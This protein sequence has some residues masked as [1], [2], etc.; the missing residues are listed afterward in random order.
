MR[1]G[2]AESV[3]RVAAY[4][5]TALVEAALPSNNQR[6]QP[7]VEVSSLGCHIT[8]I[9]HSS[10][11]SCSQSKDM[12]A[13]DTEFAYCE[14]ARGKGPESQASVLCLFDASPSA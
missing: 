14:R 11:A 2:S 1:S 13:K 7:S 10:A 12:N 8:G 9:V 5:D 3:P 4:A 6:A